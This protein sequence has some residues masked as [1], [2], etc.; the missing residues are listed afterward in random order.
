VLLNEGRSLAIQ[1]R[2][3][4]AIEFL[5][6]V[7]EKTPTDPRPL[8]LLAFCQ[9]NQGDKTA[10]GGSL[11]SACALERQGNGFN[12]SHY[13]ERVQGP[14]RTWM[15]KERHHLLHAGAGQ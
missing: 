13:M 15:E 9:G 5:R 14:T 6:V 3:E 10:A 12:W 4:E 11:K 1:I 2:Y 7:I 8:Y